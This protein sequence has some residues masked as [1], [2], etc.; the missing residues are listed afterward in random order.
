MRFRGLGPSS[1][2]IRGGMHVIRRASP[3]ISRRAAGTGSIRCSREANSARRV[4]SSSL[5][6]GENPSMRR[7]H[8]LHLWE[9]G[10]E[11]ES[12]RECPIHIVSTRCVRNRCGITLNIRLSFETSY[13]FN[14]SPTSSLMA[15]LSSSKTVDIQSGSHLGTEVNPFEHKKIIL[16]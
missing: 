14:I 8:F 12:T 4:V 3:K 15:L 9:V 6:H 10:S 5:C 11:E 7:T 16:H 13:V 1:V 2:L